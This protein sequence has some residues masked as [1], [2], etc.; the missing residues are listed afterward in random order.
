MTPRS[1]DLDEPA[2]EAGIVGLLFTGAA[3]MATVLILLFR[4]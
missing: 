1:T 3:L 4:A 2:I